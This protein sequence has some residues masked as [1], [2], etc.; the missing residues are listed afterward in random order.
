MPWILY[1]VEST[2]PVA[3]GHSDDKFQFVEPLTI[4][5]KFSKKVPTDD[6]LQFVGLA[7]QQSHG[8]WASKHRYDKLKFVV[9]SLCRNGFAVCNFIRMLVM[10][11]IVMRRV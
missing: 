7:P 5:R 2:S 1:S 9:L 4:N 3:C 11:V 10:T 6:K 8:R